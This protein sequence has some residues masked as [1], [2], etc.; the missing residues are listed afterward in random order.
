M[1]D[2]V[3]KILNK[4]NIINLLLLAILIVGI[5]FTVD[6]ARRQ[7]IL[8]SRATGS[9]VV[10]LEQGCVKKTDAGLVATC[11]KIPLSL[12][13]NFGPPT[14]LQ[15][16]NRPSNL[17]SKVSLIP[18]AY[19]LDC[20]PGDSTGECK[21][22]KGTGHKYCVY[23]PDGNSESSC[24]IEACWAGGTPGGNA[25]GPSDGSGCNNPPACWNNGGWV[26]KASAD[27]GCKSHSELT[28]NAYA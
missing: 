14:V 16:Q 28:G 5:P 4:K 3:K 26:D 15:A 21:N 23:D 7:Q 24:I 2:D 6:L 22:N 13:S 17:Q 1:L 27:N 8:N 18:E 10:V 20:T 25:G 11:L 9:E 12:T 19:A